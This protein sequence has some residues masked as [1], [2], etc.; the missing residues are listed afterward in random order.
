MVKRSFFRLQR[1]TW[2]ICAILSALLFL[3]GQGPPDIQH[4]RPSPG[5]VTIRVLTMG[6]PFTDVF[7]GAISSNIVYCSGCVPNPNFI[8]TFAPLPLRRSKVRSLNLLVCNRSGSYGQQLLL[9][10]EV[11][12]FAGNLRRTVSTTAIDLETVP[13]R[14]FVPV[15]ISTNSANTI[16]L[17]G[18]YLAAHVVAAS[19]PGGSLQ[20]QVHLIAEATSP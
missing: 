1:V 13:Q 16:L 10:V 8:N 5:G 14:V 20:L 17:P 11:R 19:G 18:E 4:G 2:V 3:A 15:P 7:S 9:T 6:T 12:D